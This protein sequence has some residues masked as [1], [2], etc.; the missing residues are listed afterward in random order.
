MLLTDKKIK[1]LIKKIQKKCEATASK[2]KPQTVDS[3]EVE[4]DSSAK[5]FNEMKKL[6]FSE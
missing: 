5:M 3:D 2:T 1:S 4:Q 6:P